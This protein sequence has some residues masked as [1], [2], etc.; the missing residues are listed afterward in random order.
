[1]CPKEKKWNS[2]SI[3]WNPRTIK[4]ISC[5]LD[6][7]DLPANLGKV[8]FIADVWKQRQHLKHSQYQNELKVP[9]TLNLLLAVKEK[10]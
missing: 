9:G 1:M 3:Y 2:L 10:A 5:W 7:N 4:Y 6:N 8:V